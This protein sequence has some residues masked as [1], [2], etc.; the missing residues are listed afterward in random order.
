MKDN[1]GH[2]RYVLRIGKPELA[3]FGRKELY[4]M[5][6]AYEKRSI[7]KA[8]EPIFSMLKG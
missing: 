3:Q 5:L 8:D 2:V 1:K 6:I 7:E 4:S